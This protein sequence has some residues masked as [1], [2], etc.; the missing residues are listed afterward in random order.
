MTQSL[1]SFNVWSEYLGVTSRDS[2]EGEGTQDKPIS[3]KGGPKPWQ[4]PKARLD[5]RRLEVFVQSSNFKMVGEKN[6]PES[7]LDR[8]I[9]SAT[10]Q[11]RGLGTS[12]LEG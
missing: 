3:C 8:G 4:K 10:V 7:I 12:L 6:E 1:Q 2:R 5:N 11:M 9:Y